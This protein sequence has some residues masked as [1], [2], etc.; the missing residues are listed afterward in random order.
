M[1]WIPE[2]KILKDLTIYMYGHGGHLGG[3][4]ILNK[5]SIPHPKETPDKI[6]LQSAKWLLI[7]GKQV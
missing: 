2:K 4:N 7:R 5:L 1:L 3:L 6:W